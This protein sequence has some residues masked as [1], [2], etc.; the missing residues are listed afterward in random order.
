MTSRP[1]DRCHSATVRTSEGKA[2]DDGVLLAVGSAQNA[3]SAILAV[4]D[5]TTMTLIAS[6]KVQGSIPF[7]FTAHSCGTNG[8]SVELLA[9]KLAGEA[10]FADPSE[11]T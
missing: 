3:E 4:I 7:G 9:R 2:E 6:A 5:A 11:A 8:R 10:D 1:A